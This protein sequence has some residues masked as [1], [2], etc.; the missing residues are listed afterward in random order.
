MAKYLRGTNKGNGFFFEMADG[1]HGWV[2]GLSRQEWDAME[3]Q[4]GRFT[5][6][7]AA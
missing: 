6:Y 4:H 1:Y 5:A 3:R 7:Y 2:Y